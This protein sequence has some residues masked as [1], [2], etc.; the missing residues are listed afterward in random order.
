LFAIEFTQ[1]PSGDQLSHCP[2]NAIEGG[3]PPACSLNLKSVPS[4]GTGGGSLGA[5]GRP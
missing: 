1:N 4:D 3:K 5:R 2:L